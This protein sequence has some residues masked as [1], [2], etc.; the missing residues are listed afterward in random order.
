MIFI[1]YIAIV[2]VNIILILILVILK[3][4]NINKLNDK[5]K[6]VI[7]KLDCVE[8]LKPFYKAITVFI[9]I[10]V[11]NILILFGLFWMVI[12]ELKDFKRNFE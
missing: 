12:S 6:M 10:P 7:K 4:M 3:V 1:N 11:L 5:F 9:L 2:M 8:D